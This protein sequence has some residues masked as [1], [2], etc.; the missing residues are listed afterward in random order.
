M[1]LPE[2]YLSCQTN[3]VDRMRFNQWTR[4]QTVYEHQIKTN[5]QAMANAKGKQ[6]SFRHFFMA[7]LKVMRD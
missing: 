7:S 4:R 6:F 1:S 5:E 2:M 3:T